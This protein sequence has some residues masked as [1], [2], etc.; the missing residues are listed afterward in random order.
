MDYLIADRWVIPEDGDAHYSEAIVSLPDCYQPNDTRRRISDEVMTRHDVGLPGEGFVF[1][2]FNNTY[3]LTPQVFAVWA[4]LLKQVPGS[5]LW[6]LSWVPEAS[7]NLAGHCREHGIDPQRLIV[8]PF[9][10]QERHLARLRLADLFLDTFPYN[11]HTT[12]SDALWAGLPVLTCMGDT[13]PSRVG[14]SLLA[15]A[16]LPELITHS[17]AEYEA[18]ALRLARE[19]ALLDGLRQRLAANRAQA[20]LFDM[21]RLA[22]HIESAYEAMVARARADQP[23]APLRIGFPAAT[24]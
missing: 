21:P 10:P 19:P 22:R 2:C 7:L 20:P 6:F 12:G 11:A 24:G 17:L 18:L 3:K 5:V 16:G 8:A 9:W 14:A 23:P 1:C 4:R 13:F 15:A